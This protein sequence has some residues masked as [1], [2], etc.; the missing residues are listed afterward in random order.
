M[1]S[2][3]VLGRAKASMFHQNNLLQSRAPVG[4]VKGVYK[5]IF[6]ILYHLKKQW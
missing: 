1:T 3:D 4:V 5:G 6:Q 2:L